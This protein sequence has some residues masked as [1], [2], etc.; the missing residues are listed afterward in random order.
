[1]E[2]L[3]PI[4]AIIED[5]RLGKMVILVDDEDREN[6][7]DLMVA[8]TRCSP[9][10]I[11]FMARHGRGLICL[12][13]TEERCKRL[14]LPL[15]VSG[16]GSRFGT[17]FTISIEAAHGVTTGISAQDRATTVQAAVSPDAKAEDIVQPGHIFPIMARKG[18][19]L[20]RAGHTE[21]GCDL[22]RL[23]GLEPA[24]VICEIL[25]E[26]GEMARL[27][28][29]IPFAKVHGLKIGTIAD[30]IRYR[31]EKEHLVHRV[32]ERLIRTEYGE[33]RLVAYE[34]EVT[35]EA[36]LALVKGIVRP[37]LPV[38][39][40]VH[41]PLELLDLLENS[42]G[43]H[44]WSVHEAMRVI[45][46]EG[47]GVI[48]LLQRKGA[49]DNLIERVRSPHYSEPKMDARTYG[50]GAQILRDLGVGKMRILSTPRK[51]P[52]MAGFGL[53][54]TEF[55]EKSKVLDFPTEKA[56]PC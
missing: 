45:A 28:D 46:R 39:V 42:D 49:H 40:R 41:E 22:T 12:T 31:N 25:K 37:E 34:D 11:N 38:L 26:N 4:E 35:N 43:G 18:G 17:N 32:A 29:L 14:S 50:I 55:I 8:A 19:V 56:Q 6:E 9:E 51:M 5:L 52:S 24:A 3:S 7:G 2:A 47:L 44:S 36:H 10:H 20:V 15:M 1:V 23:A 54:V 48:L 13:L 30:L 27:S 16:N 33:F 21:A 53:E